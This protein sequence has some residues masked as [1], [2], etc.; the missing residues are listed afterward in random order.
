MK[1]RWLP[2]W[3]N[4]KFLS[5]SFKTLDNPTPNTAQFYLLLFP[6]VHPLQ[7][8]GVS[9]LPSA[10]WVFTSLPLCRGCSPWPGMALLQATLPQ[11]SHLLFKQLK[12]LPFC[13]NLH[14]FP[15]PASSSPVHLDIA[16][17]V[18][19]LLTRCCSYCLTFSWGC[20]LWS[21]GHAFIILASNTQ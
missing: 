16:L 3:M 2:C 20:Y 7:P 1:L 4:L 19:A 6:S 8:P 15:R 12:Y 14:P 21:E 10:P 9:W 18:T 17:W 13:I 11:N 5:L